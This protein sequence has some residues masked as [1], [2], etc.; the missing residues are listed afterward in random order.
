MLT[1]IHEVH[2]LRIS[3][4]RPT[5]PQVL[6]SL[7]RCA[8][9]CASV[10][11]GSSSSPGRAPPAFPLDFLLRSKTGKVQLNTP[12]FVHQVHQDFLL[13]ALAHAHTHEHN[14]H[15]QHIHTHKHTTHTHTISHA[16]ASHISRRAR[17]AAAVAAAGARPRPSLAAATAAAC[18]MRQPPSAWP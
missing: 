6:P 8:L 9:P 11:S 4:C 1:P 5:P 7:R 13:L 14:I 12:C 2:L 18:K 17:L 10:K 16:Q 15:T 3:P